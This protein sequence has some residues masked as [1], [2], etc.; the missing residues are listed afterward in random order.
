MYVVPVHYE[1]V[2]LALPSVTA[3]FLRVEPSVL[4]D[5]ERRFDLLSYAHLLRSHFHVFSPMACGELERCLFFV[6][7]F[8][9]N[10]SLR[11]FFNFV[12]VKRISCV[13]DKVFVDVFVW[14]FEH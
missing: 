13:G 8:S 2:P 7:I 3:L 12:E 6:A 10:S 4:F 14:L 9:I 1:H 5:D 11:R